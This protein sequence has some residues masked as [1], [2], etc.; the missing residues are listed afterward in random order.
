M[1]QW[2]ALPLIYVNWDA[3]LHLLSAVNGGYS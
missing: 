3:K 1:T 2:L